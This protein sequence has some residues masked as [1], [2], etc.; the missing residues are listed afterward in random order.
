M[1][2]SWEKFVF[3]WFYKDSLA[4]PRVPGWGVQQQDCFRSEA[5]LRVLL[6][7]PMVFHDF[8]ITVFGLGG[9]FFGPAEN[10]CFI[11]FL[12]DSG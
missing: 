12:K 2:R 9:R 8:W 1:L 4:D 11:R 3:Y 7:L 6:V 10:L 5:P